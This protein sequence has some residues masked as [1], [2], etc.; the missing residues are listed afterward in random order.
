[1]FCTTGILLRILLGR[2][3]MSKMETTSSSVID[4]VLEISRIMVDEIHERDWFS[5]L[6]ILSDLLV[7][8]PH[9]RLILV[10]ATMDSDRFS[11]YFNGCPVIFVP[12]FT[13]PVK[14]FYLEDVLSFLYTSKENHLDLS[15][16]NGS[17]ES[18]EL[19]DD[20]KS[21]LDQSIDL[22]LN[23]DE[24][25]SLADFISSDSV[26]N[27]VKLPTFSNWCITSNGFY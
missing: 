18:T 16:I 13:Y 14:S 26:T 15:F 7:F 23:N 25:D 27:I 20:F 22:P 3:D 12:G 9:L 6:T 5:N 2:V 4:E 19:T 24:I 10:S 21:L 11:Q 8:Y 17:L 1:M